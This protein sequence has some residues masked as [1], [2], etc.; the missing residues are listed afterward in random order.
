MMGARIDETLQESRNGWIRNLE[1]AKETLREIFL[2]VFYVPLP[3]DL[4]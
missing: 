3:L 4:Q 2:L 1:Q